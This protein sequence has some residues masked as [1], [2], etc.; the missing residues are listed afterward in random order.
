M[1]PAPFSDAIDDF[2]RWDKEADER[3]A[4]M[5]RHPSWRFHCGCD[6][7]EGLRYK[8]RRWDPETG[9]PLSEACYRY[10]IRQITA[11]EEAQQNVRHSVKKP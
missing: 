9:V 2:A 11:K 10:R 8:P 4:S 3:H 6:I 5:K 1:S 7:G